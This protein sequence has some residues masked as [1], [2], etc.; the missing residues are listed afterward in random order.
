MLNQTPTA[1]RSRGQTLDRHL[2]A[3]E[4]ARQG[5]SDKEIADELGYSSEK[6]GGS[7]WREGLKRVGAMIPGD[8]EAFRALEVHRLDRLL[9]AAWPG[10]MAGDVES[11]TV[12]LKISER[13]GRLIKGLEVPIPKPEMHDSAEKAANALPKV[14]RLRLGEDSPHAKLLKINAEREK[15]LA[16]LE[17]TA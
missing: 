13:R 16:E 12:C 9:L 15:L 14:I 1:K 3:L 7:A 5:K 11:I 17:H 4:L 8:I 10:A 6:G 2:K